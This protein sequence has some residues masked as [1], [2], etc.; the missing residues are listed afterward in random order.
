MLG[1]C[2]LGSRAEAE[3]DKLFHDNS[4]ALS[5][6]PLFTIMEKNRRMYRLQGI[7]LKSHYERFCKK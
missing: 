4:E 6:R 5:A 1:S 2:S 7:L 3:L